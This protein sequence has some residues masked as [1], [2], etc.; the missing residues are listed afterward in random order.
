M[1]IPGLRKWVNI[2]RIIGINLLTNGE[3][4]TDTEMGKSR[5]EFQV[6]VGTHSA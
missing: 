4:I 1:Y 3:E 2:L 6:L 5:L